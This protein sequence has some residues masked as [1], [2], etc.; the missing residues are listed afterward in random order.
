MNCGM[1][2]AR[3]R[4]SSWTELPASGHFPDGVYLVMNSSTCCSASASEI[5][6]SRTACVSPDWKTKKKLNSHGGI[7]LQQRS[8][9]LCLENSAIAPFYV[10][11]NDIY[12]H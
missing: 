12:S 2:L 10:H 8:L 6:L 1:Y 9:L 7:V 3:K 4:L 11:E 5:L